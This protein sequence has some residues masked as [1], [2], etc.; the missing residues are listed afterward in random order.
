MNRTNK[1]PPIAL[2]NTEPACHDTAVISIA[3][4]PTITVE[5]YNLQ[6][7][8]LEETEL[9]YQQFEGTLIGLLRE[10]ELLPFNIHTAASL[11]T[12]ASVRHLVERYYIP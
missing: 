12:T 11:G 3:E 6:D 1:P 9:L 8:E 7:E 4:S 2:Y 10:D 5:H